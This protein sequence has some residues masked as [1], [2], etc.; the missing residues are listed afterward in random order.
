MHRSDA[1]VTPGNTLHGLPFEGAGT[2]PETKAL[3]FHHT[4][5]QDP[6]GRPIKTIEDVR[7]VLSRRGL[8]IQYIMDRDGT[9]HQMAPDLERAQ[10]I[11]RGQGIGTG[12]SN[13]NT[14]G[15]EIL[16][17]NDADV[18]PAQ[19]AS[20]TNFYKKLSTVYPGLQ[21]FGHGEINKHKQ[22][23]EGGSAVP[24]RRKPRVE[25]TTNSGPVLRGCLDAVHDARADR[26][27]VRLRSWR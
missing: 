21:A 5:D 17:A 23:T 4:G 9:I 6:Q 24:R 18:T 27:Q 14:I 3:V 25:R 15:L 1:Q 7:N 10:H 11:K 2:R 19:I 12:L 8:G 20:A 13:Q 26:Q 22:R 16:A